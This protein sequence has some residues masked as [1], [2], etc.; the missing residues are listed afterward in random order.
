[1]KNF[2]LLAALVMVFG[3][4]VPADAL[5]LSRLGGTAVYD[6]DLDITWLA[7]ANGGAGSAFDDGLSATDGRMT[8]ANANAWA[9]SLTVGGFT[10]WRLPTTIQPDSSCAVQGSLPGFPIISHGNDCTGSEMGHLFYIELGGTAGTPITTSGGSIGPFTNVQLSTSYWSST[11]YAPDPTNVAW[12]FIFNGN[13]GPGHKVN[14]VYAWGVR[15]GDVSGTPVPEPSAL[16]LLGSG[17]VGL[18]GFGRKKV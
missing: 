11:E 10:D 15:S 3:W 1:M 4:T 6:T 16:I 12:A 2:T 9:A 14:D 8:W 13:Q 5:L 17:L 7:D 18:I